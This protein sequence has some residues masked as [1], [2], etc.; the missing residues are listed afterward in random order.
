MGNNSSTDDVAF[1]PG[2]PGDSGRAHPRE[3]SGSVTR[4]IVK[5]SK[6][7][8]SPK[9]SN[10]AEDNRNALAVK[11]TLADDD[12]GYLSPVAIAENNPSVEREL[13]EEQAEASRQERIQTMEQRQ[14]SKREKAM[15]QRRT[16]NNNE[17]KTVIQANPFSRFLSVFSVEPAHPE[18]KRAFEGDEGI[19]EPSEK[20]LRPTDS[21]DQDEQDEALEENTKSAAFS[22]STT[23]LAAMAVAAI[24]VLVAFHMKKK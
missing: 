11:T 3:R 19:E 7:L 20:K 15:Q 2:S 22:S 6:P 10:A 1:S 9:N 4:R 16:S 8:V 12:A 17:K 13:E 5:A 18:H 24:S 21:V 14:R 23:L